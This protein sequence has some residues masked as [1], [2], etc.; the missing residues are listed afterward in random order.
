MIL[1]R[2]Q[3][4]MNELDVWCKGRA[5][6]LGCPF[7]LF[8]RR[9]LSSLVF[10]PPGYPPH[11]LI[12]REVYKSERFC[13]TLRESYRRLESSSSCQLTTSVATARVVLAKRVRWIEGPHS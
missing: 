10:P 8:P 3:Y 4:T 6:R 5:Y 1:L 13:T 9:C 12:I 11:H 2:R 7:L